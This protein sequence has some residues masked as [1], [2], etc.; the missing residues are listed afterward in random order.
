MAFGARET[1]FR[2]QASIRE[3]YEQRKRS[4]KDQSQASMVSR[5]GC[6]AD[7]HVAVVYVKAISGLS[8]ES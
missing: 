8:L 3:N 6:I 1:G 4:E 7:F 2:I 5:S